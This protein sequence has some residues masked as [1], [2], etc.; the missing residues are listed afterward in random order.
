[1]LHEEIQQRTLQNNISL[2]IWRMHNK[3]LRLNTADTLISYCS[4]TYPINKPVNEFNKH[5]KVRL[6]FTNY[7]FTL[8]YF[9]TIVISTHYIVLCITLQFTKNILQQQKSFGD[10][11]QA[12]LFSNSFKINPCRKLFQNSHASE[13]SR[14]NY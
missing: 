1:M 5:S 13:Q 4:S 11:S 3:K 10:N 2:H 9:Q 14:N 8:E 7:Y 6:L 12:I